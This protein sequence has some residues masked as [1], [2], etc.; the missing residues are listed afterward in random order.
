MD[1][2]FTEE[3]GLYRDMVRAVCDEH[4][5]TRVVRDMENDAVGIPAGLWEKM[6][7]TGLLGMMLPEEYG[8][9]GLNTVDRVVIF[10]QLG[11]ALAPG[12]FF[13]SS[14]MSALAILK[15][16][17]EAQKS[18]LLPAIGA[19]DLIV[20]PAWLEPDNGFGP[21]G[22]QLRATS[23]GDGYVLNGVKRHVLYARAAQKLLVLARTG[24]AADAIEL[25]LVDTDAPGVTLQQQKS[26]ASDTQYRVDFANVAVPAANRIG[27]PGGGWATWNACMHEGIVLLA[28]FAV[29]GAERA[30]EMTVEYSK[31]REQFGKP[32]G[33]FQSLSHYMADGFA[34]I[35]GAKV[36]VLEAAWAQDKG[37][38]I[39]RLAPMAKLFACNTFRDVTAKCE[40]IHGGYGFTLEYDIQLFFRRAKQQQINWWDSR[41]L[42]NLIAA[43]VLD[44]DGRTI[45][46]LFEV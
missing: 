11:R 1:L 46:D 8:G 20:T 45:E 24:D 44:G 10:E 25:L 30:L 26:M 29:G 14:V 19:G 9:I 37:R 5:T 7:E 23:R 6:K 27:A 22:V 12:P 40:Q 31:G 3:Q 32:I 16:G 18:G 38:S 2:N 15:A 34:M 28:S 4:S 33:S 43:E 41:Y 21:E 36:L 17:S 42:E 35:E 13:V 39:A